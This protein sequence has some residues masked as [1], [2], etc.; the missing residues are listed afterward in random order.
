[1]LVLPVLSISFINDNGSNTAKGMSLL[2]SSAT[3]SEASPALARGLDY[4]ADV[5]AVQDETKGLLWTWL[6]QL[7]VF[8][9]LPS[10]LT[11]H[12]FA[13]LTISLCCLGRYF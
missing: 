12:G 2:M 6:V 10:G 5:L 3:P 8:P 7:L 1:M 11:F 9:L 13:M 4:L